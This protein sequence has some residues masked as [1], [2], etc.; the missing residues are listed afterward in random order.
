[1]MKKPNARG[2][3]QILVFSI[4]AL[5]VFPANISAKRKT[6]GA[7]L[8]ILCDKMI[9]GELIEV[10]EDSLLI[11]QSGTPS[12]AHVDF[13]KINAIMMKSKR[14]SKIGKWALHGLLIGT[15][16]GVLY[17]R[18]QTYGPF[19]THGRAANARLHGIMFGFLGCGLGFL[20]GTAR[21][22]TVKYKE[23]YNKEESIDNLSEIV[24]MLNKKARYFNPN[25]MKKSNRA[26]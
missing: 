25:F 17:G 20:G 26:R 1:M 13:S 18:S 8:K 4:S 11:M 9:I 5:L 12:V 14:K 10:R 19:D 7:Q 2:I 3:Y 23:I 15:A 6:K 21:S 22:L 24:T 16:A